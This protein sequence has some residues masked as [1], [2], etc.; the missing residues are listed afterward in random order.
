LFPVL[1]GTQRNMKKEEEEEE[2]FEG[3]EEPAW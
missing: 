1:C 3:K 2:E